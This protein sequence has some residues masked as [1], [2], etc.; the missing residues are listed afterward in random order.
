MYRR[1]YVGFDAGTTLQATQ[2]IGELIVIAATGVTVGLD[3]EVV[4]G[5][6]QG[7]ADLP[8]LI[9]GGD[10]L[11]DGIVQNVLI[12][13]GRQSA[14]TGLNGDCFT[15]MLVVRDAIVPLFLCLERLNIG[16]SML[17]G[18]PLSAQSRRSATKKSRLRCRSGNSR[19]RMPCLILLARHWR[20]CCRTA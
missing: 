6:T 5:E 3:Q 7:A 17:C 19:D 11:T 4:C 13:D 12:P 2:G 1:P 8:P 15:V 9:E 14:R 20:L 10:E 18:S 16:C